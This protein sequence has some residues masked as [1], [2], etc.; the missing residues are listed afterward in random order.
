MK[1]LA[2]DTSTDVCAVALTEDQRLISEYRTLNRRAHA[3][4]ILPAIDWILNDAQLRINQLDGIAVSIGPGSFT[5]LR[6]G[7][8]AVKG[9]VLATNLP[10]VAVPS[11]DAIASLASCWEGQIC[12]LVKCQSHEAYAALYHFEGD[13][14]IR[15]SD[16][17]LINLASLAELIHRRT[18]ILN[19]GINDLSNYLAGSRKDLIVLAPAHL[20]LASGYAIARLGFDRFCYQKIEDVERLEPFY[21][22]DFKAKK[23]QGLL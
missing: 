11:L 16:Y 13:V 10:V 12:P 14:L 5:G 3:E 18:L 21:L 15:D 7:L 1:I 9:L 23:K 8:A 2:I 22:K 17:L 20:C 19:M 6:I 4:K